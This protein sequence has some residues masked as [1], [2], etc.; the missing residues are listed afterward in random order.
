MCCRNYVAPETIKLE[1]GVEVAAISMR[2]F[3][4]VKESKKL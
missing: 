4:S 1:L 2:H 3:L